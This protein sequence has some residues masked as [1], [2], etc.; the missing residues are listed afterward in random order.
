MV[1]VCVC[2]CVRGWG[3]QWREHAGNWLIRGQHHFKPPEEIVSQA[4]F[5][6]G[7]RRARETTEEVRQ[8]RCISGNLWFQTVFASLFF[9]SVLIVTNLL[10]LHDYLK[11]KWF[12]IHSH[13]NIF[14]AKQVCY[15]PTHTHL[16]GLLVLTW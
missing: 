13:L 1:C 6:L 16:T 9:S 7:K 15:P 14:E 2:V 3:L 5:F 4:R 10:W 11:V 8:A 12:H